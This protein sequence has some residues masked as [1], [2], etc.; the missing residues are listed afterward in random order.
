MLTRTL[1]SLLVLALPVSSIDAAPVSAVFPS[2]AVPSN[3]LSEGDRILGNAFRKKK[4]AFMVKLQATVVSN[5]PDDTEGSRHQRFIVKLASGQ[6]LLIVHNIDL[7]PRV[8]KP[9]AG[10]RV[11]IHGEYI[12]NNKGGLIHKTH[13][14]PQGDDPDGW[15]LHKG[16]K[17]L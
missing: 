6:T 16:R 17:Y 11:I 15:I 14:D 1:L 7:A 9:K 8:L 10:Q 2:F 12:W 13:R 5:L 3:K 4:T